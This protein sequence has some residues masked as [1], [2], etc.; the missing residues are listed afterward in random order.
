MIAYR[1]KLNVERGPNWLWVKVAEPPCELREMPPLADRLQFLLEEHFTYR[2]VLELDEI[3]AFSGEL[4]GELLRLNKWIRGRQGMM[5][6]CGL[7]HEN[8]AILQ[9]CE[10]DAFL[11]TYRDRLEAVLGRPRLSQQSGPMRKSV[12]S[13]DCQ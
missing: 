5:R 6:L 10:Q 8:A 9:C 2:L 4:I 7:S 1:W 13:N 11:P 3:K 12:E